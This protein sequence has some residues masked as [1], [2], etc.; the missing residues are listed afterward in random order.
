MWPE[1]ASYWPRRGSFEPPHARRARGLGELPT[2]IA[3]PR[4]GSSDLEAP[5]D[6]QFWGAREPEVGELL[7]SPRVPRSYSVPFSLRVFPPRSDF[8]HNHVHPLRLSSP[9]CLPQPPSPHSC[10]L[11]RGWGG[12]RMGRSPPP[13]LSSAAP[14]QQDSLSP[15]PPA[16]PGAGARWALGVG[17]HG[18][19]PAAVA[20]RPGGPW[21]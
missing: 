4:A 21:R 7:R 9:R 18:R 12:S 2:V 10:P 17:S 6:P 16:R 11:R 15:T 13:R 14:G 5:S 8:L 20:S 19:G 3:T 1:P